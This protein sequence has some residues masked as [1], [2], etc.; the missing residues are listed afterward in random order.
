MVADWRRLMLGVAG[1]AFAAVLMFMQNGFRNALLDSPVQL[2][3]LVDCDLVAISVARF[4]LPT[5]QTFPTK[6]FE[7]AISDPDVVASSPIY[8]ERSRAQ[9]RVAG[10]P[11]RPIRVVAME[12]NSGWFLDDQLD[13]LMP[14]LRSFGT[15]LLD[16]HSRSSY[17]FE[18]R[19]PQRLAKQEI[20]LLDRSLR[21][22][23]LVEIGTDFANDGTLVIGRDTFARFFPFRTSGLSISEIDLGMFRVK[24][25]ANQEQVAAR[26]TSLDPIAWKVVPRAA[27]IDRE[28]QFWNQQTPIGMIF[29]IGSMMG[30][31]VGVIICYQ[32]LFNSIHDSLPEY[33]TLKAMG[34]EDRYFVML[35]IRQAI[36]LSLLGFIPALITSWLMFQT[37]QWAIGLPMIL[38][39]SRIVL[40]LGLTTVMCLV[41][42]L[43]ALRR[44][45]NAD[46]A[47][48]Y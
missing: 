22:I 12:P 35:V 15:A 20:E 40:I 7:R 18:V 30:F 36:Y 25:G 5:D 26:L 43:L 38:T 32:I 17:G 27:L 16:K 46:P 31:A 8:M 19:N 9:L 1:V 11:R 34:Y 33:A 47:S 4:S 37:L 3:E 14:S 21:V 10:Q 41:S 2:L 39:P 29:F 13:S 45:L 44:L 28:I 23:G 48:L 6:L 24:D 42:G